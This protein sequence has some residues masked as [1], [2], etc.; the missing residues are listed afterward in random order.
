M[1]EEVGDL[2]ALERAGLFAGRYHVLG[3]TLS[4]LDGIG[5]EA[6]GID[7]LVR[8]VAGERRRAR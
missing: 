5:P 8:R 6:L 4:A 3:G 2:W 7:R 1:V